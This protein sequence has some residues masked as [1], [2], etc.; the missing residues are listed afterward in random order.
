LERFFVEGVADVV[1]WAVGGALPVDPP[2][3]S[4]FGQL[5]FQLH[6]ALLEIQQRNNQH[7]HRGRCPLPVGVGYGKA[8]RFF[9]Q[10]A[11]VG[12]TAKTCADPTIPATVDFV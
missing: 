1:S 10:V 4:P 7:L 5:L 8:S 6:H 2:A 11:P 12:G 9:H 3:R